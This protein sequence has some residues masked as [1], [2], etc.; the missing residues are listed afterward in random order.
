MYAKKLV[1]LLGQKNILE[2]IDPNRSMSSIESGALVT[3]S[4]GVYFISIS[5]G[6][7]IKE[8]TNITM[9]ISA[10]APIAQA[11]LGKLSG[12]N[13]IWQGKQVEILSI[14]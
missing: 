7:I 14:D 10:V 4:A 3:T 2:S 13:F 11:M 8:G 1:E 5:L 6:V 12:Q 9:A